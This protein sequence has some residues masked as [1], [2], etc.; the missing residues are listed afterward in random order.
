[1]LLL[2]VSI[3]WQYW[4]LAC[5]PR[6]GNNLGLLGLR[7]SKH[8]YVN[9]REYL[10]FFSC[11][12][13]LTFTI[14]ASYRL[15]PIQCPV[16]IM[17]LGIHDPLPSFF[18]FWPNLFITSHKNFLPV[19][20]LCICYLSFMSESCYS[21]NKPSC[22]FHSAEGMNAGGYG[23]LLM[24]IEQ[25]QGEYSV[26]ISFLNLITTLVRVSASRMICMWNQL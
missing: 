6:W 5:Q 7:T 4:L 21:C 11:R 3:V 12:F 20:N 17:W 25:P 13:G 24:S 18:F 15:L 8:V 2:L 19:W 9:E 23:N 1:M 16:W 10:Y 26:T 14:Q 22:L